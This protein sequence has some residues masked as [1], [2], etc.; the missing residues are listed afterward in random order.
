MREGREQGSKPPGTQE[1]RDPQEEVGLEGIRPQDAGMG[2]ARRQTEGQWHTKTEGEV[3]LWV[4]TSVAKCT[5][6]SLC[7]RAGRCES[8][9]S[10]AMTKLRDRWKRHT[11]RLWL[12]ARSG[13]GKRSLYR[14]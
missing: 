5:G 13:F 4:S 12:R 8:P 11:V 7:G 1:R 6:T 10:R 9:P 14:H 2:Q 3:K